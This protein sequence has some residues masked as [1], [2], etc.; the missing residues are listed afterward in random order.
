MYEISDGMILYLLIEK[1]K[2]EKLNLSLLES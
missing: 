2:P 1:K